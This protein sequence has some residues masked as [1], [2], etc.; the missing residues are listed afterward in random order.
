MKYSVHDKKCQPCSETWRVRDKAHG[1]L[2]VTGD[3]N[4]AFKM[5]YE[6]SQSLCVKFN[7]SQNPNSVHPL[8]VTVSEETAERFDIDTHESTF[9]A[10][11]RK[12]GADIDDSLLVSVHVR[13]RGNDLIPFLADDSFESLNGFPERTVP[14]WCTASFFDHYEIDK[15]DLYFIK[16]LDV[17]PVQKVIIEA[18]NTDV[19]QWT[20]KVKFGAGLIVSVC[21][22]KVL[23]REGDVFLAPFPKIFLEDP[24]FDQGYYFDL[25]VLECVPVCQGMLTV[26]TEIVIILNSDANINDLHLLKSHEYGMLGSGSKPISPKNTLDLP[27]SNICISDFSLPLSTLYSNKVSLQNGACVDDTVKCDHECTLSGQHAAS[28]GR[29]RY[30]AGKSSGFVLRPTVVPKKNL[31][32]KLLF[33]KESQVTFDPLY[34]MGMSRSLMLKHGLFDGAVVRVSSLQ[35]SSKGSTVNSSS[36]TSVEDAGSDVDCLPSSVGSGKD[37]IP[38]VRG[39]QNSPIKLSQVKM[40]KR[41]F[42]SSK[43]VYV[44]PLLL[45]NLQPCPSSLSSPLCMFEVSLYEDY[46]YFMKLI[47]M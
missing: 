42:D 46:Q 11:L 27:V 39:Y 47:Y 20:Q 1:C 33:Q 9:V 13:G 4:Y 8:H 28:E 5:S 6:A 15:N 21:Q 24:T 44:S 40:L 3:N 26:N 31:W 45:F 35:P 17:Y 29:L 37:Y 41:E 12:A 18:K 22:E 7:I 32:Y 14:V 23:V 10:G 2:W 16:T 38:S 43:D 34:I 19:L 36:K 30:I 25:Q